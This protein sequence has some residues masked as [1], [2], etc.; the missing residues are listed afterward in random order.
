[1]KIWRLQTVKNNF[2]PTKYISHDIDFVSD[3]INLLM[4]EIKARLT[5]ENVL[6]IKL[7]NVSNEER[8]LI[9]GK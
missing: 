7:E 6:E 1:M 3:D 2:D 8:Y 9:K 5:S 4:N